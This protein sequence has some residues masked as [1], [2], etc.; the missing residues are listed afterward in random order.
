MTWE[1]IMEKR[2]R[3]SKI[4]KGNVDGKEGRGRPKNR[5]DVMSIYMG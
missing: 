1:Y 5:G 4:R 3:D 2:N